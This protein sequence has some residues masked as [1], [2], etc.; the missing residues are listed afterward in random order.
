MIEDKSFV[1]RLQDIPNTVQ[2][3]EEVAHLLSNAAGDLQPADI[4]VQSLASSV[5]YHRPSKVAT[6]MFKSMPKFLAQ[7][8]AVDC[9]PISYQDSQTMWL[10]KGF[11]GFTPLNNVDPSTHDVEL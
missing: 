9:W 4:V 10:D 11:L 7:K 2:S 8:P 3:P 6:L 5:T 1:Y